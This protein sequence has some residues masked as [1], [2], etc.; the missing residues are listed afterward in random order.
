M[1]P[2][3]AFRA[4]VIHL[5][6]Q[7]FPCPEKPHLSRIFRTPV[8]NPCFPEA[9]KSCRLSQAPRFKNP[10]INTLAGRGWTVPDFFTASQALRS[11]H[12]GLPAS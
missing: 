5:G 8:Q 6:K 3:C 11:L 7:R 4:A 10:I 1:L 2:P 12:S 9:V